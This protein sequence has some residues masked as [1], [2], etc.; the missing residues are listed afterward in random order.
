ME[1]HT[2]TFNNFLQHYQLKVQSQGVWCSIYDSAIPRFPE[3]INSGKRD[4]DRL[5]SGVIGMSGWRGP[6]K[7]EDRSS[8]FEFRGDGINLGGTG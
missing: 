2:I 6:A 1:E 4:D 5:Y 3:I 8:D 7:N